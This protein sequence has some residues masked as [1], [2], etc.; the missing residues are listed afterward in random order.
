LA[1]ANSIFTGDKLLTA[2]NAGDD[3]DAALF[4]KLGLVPLQARGPLDR[5]ETEPA[6]AARG[7]ACGLAPPGPGRC[8][9]RGHRLQRREDA[10]RNEPLRR[11]RLRGGRRPAQR[12]M[13]RN[14][15]PDEGARRRARSRLRPPAGLFRDFAR[16]PTGLAEVSR[17]P[18]PRRQ[19]PRPGRIDAADARFLL[20]GAPHPAADPAI[21]RVDRQLRGALTAAGLGLAATAG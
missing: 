11:P 1:G 7:W 17:R 15:G 16:R 3:S 2:P 21:A 4:D 10:D 9:R 18:L 6:R 8:R 14:L 5:P 12:A 13:G 19:L 20:Q